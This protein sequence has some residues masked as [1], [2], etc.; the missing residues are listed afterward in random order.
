MV[1]LVLGP[2]VVLASSD[3]ERYDLALTKGLVRLK[4]EH[5][6][7]A[8]RLFLE[9][10]VARPGDTEASYH[11]GR[12]QI[13]LRRYEA[14]E[15]TFRAMLQRDARSGRGQLG[16]GMALYYH[17]RFADAV[18]SL[19]TAEKLLP[20][21]PLVYFYQGLS[22]QKL[23]AYD[24]S[25]RP[26]ATAGKL[27]QDLAPEIRYLLGVAYYKQ[28]FGEEA[29]EQ[30]EEVLQKEPR[31]NLA[32]SANDLLKVLA[33]DGRHRSWHI[34]AAISGQYDTN[35]V[36]LPLGIQPSGGP[37][38][39]SRKSDYRAVLQLATELRPFQNDSS[40]A[41]ITYSL[42]QSFH[43]T[44]DGFDVQ[45]HSP[46]LFVIK[47]LGQV[48]ARLHYNFD[49][50][51]VGRSPFLAAHTIQ[52][53][54]RVYE[55]RSAVTEIQL[56][57]QNKDFQDDRFPINAFRDGKNWLVGA[58]QYLIFS[59]Q[60]GHIRFGYTYDTDR[61][62]GGDPIVAVPGTPTNADWAYVGHR[63]S[64]GIEFP[65]FPKTRFN[66][67][68]D[69]YR[70]QYLNPNSFS[71]TGAQKRAD[72]IYIFSGTVSREIRPWLSALFQ[73]GYT[74]DY[75]NIGVFDYTRAVYSIML[76]GSL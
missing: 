12:T 60:S 44:L 13:R 10:L 21:E 31:S 29:R 26:L 8:E 76:L 50:V 18:R 24:R 55:G 52:P 30:L 65:L 39:I 71:V 15:Q 40:A 63:V 1:L 66:A 51:T 59:R 22:H 58:T 5:Y 61:T 20:Q 73:Y 25:V 27:A 48:E 45:N 19:E 2:N 43:R 67:G 68:M 38:G 6:A 3:P 37:A 32:S 35:V 69:Y 64:A 72:D 42:Y 46:G 70:Q 49:Y 23:G 7:A 16:L 11:L 41:G 57:Y 47:R 33:G 56:R 36:L 75:S 28:G 34:S 53:V 62:G 54:I 17:G 4:Q 9:A 14:A 74:R